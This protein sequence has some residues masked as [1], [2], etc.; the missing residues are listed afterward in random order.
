MSLDVQVNRRKVT[1]IIVGIVVIGVVSLLLASSIKVVDSGHR[2]VLL[3]WSEV[4][5]LECDPTTGKCIAIKPPLAEGL[6]LVVP[7]QDEVVNV[8]IRTKKFEKATTSASRDLQDVSTSVALNYHLAPE[9]VHKMY[10]EVGLDYENRIINPAVDETVKQVTALYNAEELITKRSF[11]KQDIENVLAERLLRFDIILD[12]ISITDFRFTDQFSSAIEAKVTAEQQAL[13]QENR[14]RVEEAKAQQKEAIAEG[15][16]LARIQQAEGIKQAQI[17]EA[18]GKAQAILLEANAER[19]R[20]ELIANA[21]QN[22]PEIL[23]YLRILNWNGELPETLLN[24]NGED[25]MTLL[26]IPQKV[27]KNYQTDGGQQ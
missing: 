22:N 10:R 7:I 6:H 24:G 20:L 19:E 4:D 9:L 8:E 21:I 15:D 13:E 11:V 14:I 25:I 23:E 16:K 3:H 18:E 26:Q 2:G 5:G 1:A 27:T 12:Q 17:T